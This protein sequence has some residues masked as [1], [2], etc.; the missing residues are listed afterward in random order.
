MEAAGYRHARPKESG[1]GGSLT[2]H[3]L[4]R[5]PL[6]AKGKYVFLRYCLIPYG[7]AEVAGVLGV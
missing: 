2:T 7:V 3:T 6:V 4:E 5:G 1:E